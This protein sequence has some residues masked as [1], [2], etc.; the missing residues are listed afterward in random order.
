VDGVEMVVVV[1]GVEMVGDEQMEFPQTENG[2][3]L[4]KIDMIV[5]NAGVSEI[6]ENGI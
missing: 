3:A 1:D 4:L 5:T 6:N 2:E